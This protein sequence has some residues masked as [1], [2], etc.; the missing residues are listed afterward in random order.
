MELYFIRHAEAQTPAIDTK[1]PDRLDR[2]DRYGSGDYEGPLTDR[3]RQQA[4]AAGQ[5][6]A[7][8]GIETVISSPTTRAKQ[9]AEIALSEAGGRSDIVLMDEL[10]AAEALINDI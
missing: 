4:K 6:L 10:R 8:R 9:T 2:I 7:R 3:G 5:F 1:A